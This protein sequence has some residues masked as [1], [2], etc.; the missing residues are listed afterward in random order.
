MKKMILWVTLF[1][2]VFTLVGCGGEAGNHVIYFQGEQ[3]P[4]NVDPLLATT[5]S[6]RMVMENIYESLFRIDSQGKVIPAA[7]L[8]YEFSADG[9][10]C[11][12]VLREG[13]SW[14]DGTAITPADFIFGLKR[15]VSPET[16]APCGKQLTC[17]A[18][19]TEILAGKRSTDTLGVS[20]SGNNTLSFSLTGKGDGLLAALAVTKPFLKIAR[21]VTAP[22]QTM[23]FPTGFFKSKAGRGKNR[24]FLSV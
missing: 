15:A 10:T 12:V 13:L 16:K 18:G 14:S 2:L 5:Q 6:E 24:I 7:A 3:V 22:V 8:G 23:F 11:T 17:I 9:K 4:K 20:A 19:A 21:A 1:A